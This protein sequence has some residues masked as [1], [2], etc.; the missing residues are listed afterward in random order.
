MAGLKTSANMGFAIA[1]VPCFADI[2][3]Q[4]ASSV[5]RMKF[6]AK[7][8][9]NRKRSKRLPVMFPDEKKKLKL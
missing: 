7:T 6:I 3:V 2:F 1:G 8:P 5:L 9:R 4:G